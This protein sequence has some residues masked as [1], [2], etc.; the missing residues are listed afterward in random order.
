MVSRTGTALPTNGLRDAPLLRR[1][2]DKDNQDAWADFAFYYRK[3]IYN[4]VRRMG[5]SHHDADEV[6]QSVLIKSWNALPNF[7]YKPEK[8]RFRGW[9]CKVAGN[10]AKNLL[11]AR[12]RAAEPLEC[13]DWDADEHSAP[14]NAVV[15]PEIEEFAEREWESY[16]PE[17]AWK[18]VSKDFEPKVLKC[19]SLFAEGVDAKE[20]ARKLGIADSSVYV[21]KKRVQDRLAQE[22]ARL[23]KEL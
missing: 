9:L 16:L 3:Y 5:L 13:L 10:E 20:I 23:K 1:V 17:L 22:V 4:L 18:S 19:F 6:V 2:K 11:R 21:Y 12:G 15:R 8:G 7:E 14:E